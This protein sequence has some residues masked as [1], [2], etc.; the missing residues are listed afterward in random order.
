M[1]IKNSPFVVAEVEFDLEAQAI[2]VN[3][4]V[5]R[6]FKVA[7]EKHSVYTSATLKIGLD[8]EHDVDGV[9][10]ARMQLRMQHRRLVNIGTDSLVLRG[11]HPITL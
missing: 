2:V 7:A 5:M 1:G 11:R 4:R 10:K 8:Q 3:Q 9:G 6:G